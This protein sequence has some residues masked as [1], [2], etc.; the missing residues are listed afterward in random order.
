MCSKFNRREHELFNTSR[1]RWRVGRT[2][3][4]A[5]GQSGSD[6]RSRSRWR[7]C[8]GSPSAAQQICH[9]DQI[10]RGDP[11]AL[12]ITRAR[13]H[14]D[15]FFRRF[16]LIGDLLIEQSLQP[17]AN[18]SRSRGGQGCVILANFDQVR[19]CDTVERRVPILWHRGQQLRRVIGLEGNPSLRLS[20]PT[21]LMEC[22]HVETKIIG[23][24]IVAVCSRC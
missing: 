5:S 1:K 4:S 8:R 24:W 23:T 12:S 14:F 22:R 10:C 11:R 20:W 19:L 17:A 7:C 18:T 6:R 13:L 15:G 21:A 16:P 2:E 9:P 3:G